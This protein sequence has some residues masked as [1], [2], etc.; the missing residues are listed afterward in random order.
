MFSDIVLN[1]L[2]KKGDSFEVNNCYN[3]V[4]IYGTCKVSK[5][6]KIKPKSIG[7]GI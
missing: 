7:T 1:K 3:L 6:T 2:Q 4:A 5:R